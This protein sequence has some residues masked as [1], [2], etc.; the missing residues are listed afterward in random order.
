MLEISK[1]KKPLQK[2]SLSNKSIKFDK[3]KFYGAIVPDGIFIIDIDT[4]NKKRE[5]VEVLKDKG[6]ELWPTKNQ[7]QLPTVVKIYNFDKRKNI[8]TDYVI[9]N[10]S[11]LIIHDSVV[12]E[13]LTHISNLKKEQL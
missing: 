3:N 12:K 11:T 4:K 1:N 2:R 5:D 7:R 8:Q 9:V 10:D 13:Y 6:I